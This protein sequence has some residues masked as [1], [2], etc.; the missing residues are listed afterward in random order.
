MRVCLPET[1]GFQTSKKMKYNSPKAVVLKKMSL[2]E[3]D[4]VVLSKLD[5]CHNPSKETCIHAN[6]QCGTEIGAR[7]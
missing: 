5:R 3:L 7:F 4:P 2:L 1:S 6:K